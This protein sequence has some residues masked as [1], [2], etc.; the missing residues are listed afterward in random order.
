M[1]V[2]LKCVT[3]EPSAAFREMTRPDEDWVSSLVV[4][5][6]TDGVSAIGLTVMLAV[7]SPPPRPPSLLLRE[8]C[9]LN[10]AVPSKSAAGEN[11][12]PALPWATVIKSPLLICVV[13][14]FWNS[15]PFVIFVILKWVTSAPSA[16]FREITRPDVVC[17]SSSV[18]ADVIGGVSATGLTVMWA[19][20]A[21][22][23]PVPPLLASPATSNVNVLPGL[24]KFADGLNLSPALASAK[25]MKSS[26][27]ICVVPSF[28]NSVPFVMLVILKCVISLPSTALREMTRPLVDCVSSLVVA[29]VTV[30]KSATGIDGNR[31][32]DQAAA[33]AGIR[34][35]QR[36]LNLEA[37][38][39]KEIGRRA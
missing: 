6:V 37:G 11:F 1:L 30:G 28:L 25:V 3:S 22:P 7:A 14:S 9:T 20:A 16:A 13:P 5:P 10:V 15:V 24:N 8:P 33:E 32:G 39:A 21:G 23:S 18:V 36:C 26:P 38:R 4:V 31:R 17:V 29:S 34:I 27:L 12:R 35:T 2:I 19:V